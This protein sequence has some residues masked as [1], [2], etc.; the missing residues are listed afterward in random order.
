MSPGV[1]ATSSSGRIDGEVARRRVSVF[2]PAR[3]QATVEA[4]IVAPVMVALVIVVVQ[5][6]MVARDQ[7]MVVHAA[8][9]AARVVAVDPTPGAGLAA[10]RE[11]ARLD[12]AR[13]EVRVSG[14]GGV[15]TRV[16]VM[17]E[18]DSPTELPLVGPLVGD[19]PLRAEATMRVER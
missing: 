18:Y 17:V 13:L 12:P 14:R 3:G 6:A 7:V 5:V 16:R 11:A 8:R 9:E 1:G 15:G 2:G 10:A 4:A 19:V